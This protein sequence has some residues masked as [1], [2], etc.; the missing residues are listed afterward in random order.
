MSRIRPSH[1]LALALALALVPAVR[2]QDPTTSPSDYNTTPPTDDTSY[3]DDNATI[4]NSTGSTDGNGTTDP[5]VSA[6]DFDTTP[7]SD[8]TSYLN[9]TADVPAA[10]DS[11]TSTPPPGTAATTTPASATGA[12]AKT[13]GFETI[14]LLA[15]LAVAGVALRRR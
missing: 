7:P 5:T 8:D 9:D 3:M 1:A 15:A 4:A 11:G 6:S 13:P 14:A 2:A 10:A 12:P